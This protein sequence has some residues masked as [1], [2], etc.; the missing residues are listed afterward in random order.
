M[1]RNAKEIF[2]IRVIVGCVVLSASMSVI[3][4][5]PSGKH[6]FDASVKLPNQAVLKQ[7]IASV[8]GV[9]Q[10]FDERTKLSQTLTSYGKT[11]SDV[12]TSVSGAIGKY[13]ITVDNLEDQL[14]TYELQSPLLNAILRDYPAIIAKL[15]D[16]KIIREEKIIKEE[17]L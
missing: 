2:M 1:K 7:R 9:P 10:Q 12:V 6:I 11:V 8:P 14:K 16:E 5:Q 15:K 3:G 4:A 13:N 17:N